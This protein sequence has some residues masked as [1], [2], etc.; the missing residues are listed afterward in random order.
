M[1]H[2]EFVEAHG[3]ALALLEPIDEPF[4]LIALA[5]ARVRTPQKEASHVR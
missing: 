4:D 2:S 3:D 1:G 5:A